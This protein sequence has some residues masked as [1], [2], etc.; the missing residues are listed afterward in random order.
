M[1][2]LKRSGALEDFKPEK[3]H[4]WLSWGSRHSDD[5]I[6]KQY[7]LF[8]RFAPAARPLGRTSHLSVFGKV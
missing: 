6:K 3:L 7:E 1:K 2:V 4:K 8:K 5:P